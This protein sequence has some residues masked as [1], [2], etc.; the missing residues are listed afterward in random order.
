MA[1]LRKWSKENC[2][3]M[4]TRLNAIEQ[5]RK[6]RTQSHLIQE[7]DIQFIAVKIGT[8]WEVV[9][10]EVGIQKDTVAKTGS[11]ATTAAS[12]MMSRWLELSK[13][14]RVAPPTWESLDEII[15]RHDRQVASEIEKLRKSTDNK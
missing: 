10:K 11:E 8:Y 15:G 14:G 5:E 9:A 12:D 2:G 13:T 7:T 6:V 4:Q 3:K 1:S